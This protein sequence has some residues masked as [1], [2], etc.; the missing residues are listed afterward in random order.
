MTSTL[1][2]I[3][4]LAFCLVLAAA[5]SVTGAQPASAQDYGTQNY[6]TQQSYPGGFTTSASQTTSNTPSGSLPSNIDA[7]TGEGAASDGASQPNLAFTGSEAQT[8]GLVGSGLILAGAA[9]TVAARR[10]NS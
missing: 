7:T 3:L 9:V 5:L 1:R 8:L 2:S 4:T 10:R 6:N